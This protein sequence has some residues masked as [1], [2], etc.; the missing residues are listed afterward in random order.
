MN[1]NSSFK[2]NY[3]CIV[4]VTCTLFVMYTV[5]FHCTNR[6]LS[7]KLSHTPQF[8][9]LATCFELCNINVYE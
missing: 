9:Y 7:L 6:P 8:L 3:I 5:G 2:I 1:Q 4:D